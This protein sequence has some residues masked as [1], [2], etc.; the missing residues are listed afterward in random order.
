M[1]GGRDGPG[2]DQEHPPLEIGLLRPLDVHA[3]VVPGQGLA[4]VL[5]E[6]LHVG[7]GGLPLVAE[8]HDLQAVLLPYPALDGYSTR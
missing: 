2:R 6:D 3:D 1:V 8:P 5:V 4:H 7:H